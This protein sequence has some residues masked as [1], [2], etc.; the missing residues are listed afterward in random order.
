[1]DV[2]QLPFNQFVGIQTAVVP[3]RLLCL[4]AGAQYLNHLGTVHA[5]AQLAL[6]EA[7]S[8]EFL[9]RALG[10]VV[11]IVP[12]VRRLECKFRKPAHGALTSTAEVEPGAMDAL[13]A[14]LAGKGRALI[15]VKV[16]VHDE[17]GTHVL[18]AT[19][20]WF[21]TRMPTP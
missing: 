18:S 13:Q 2:T 6:V 12:V 16:E 11:G 19:V 20:D 8:G 4:P 5:S 21:I 1:M 17:E 10:E 14:D 3:D 15:G 9:V 7:S